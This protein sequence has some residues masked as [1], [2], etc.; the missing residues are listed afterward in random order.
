MKFRFIAVIVSCLPLAACSAGPK[1]EDVVNLTKAFGATRGMVI[2]SVKNLGC[3]KAKEGEVKDSG[4]HYR[5]K[6]ETTRGTQKGTD[7]IY[8][9]KMGENW[10]VKGT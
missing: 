7:T 4:E 2:D 5:C 3:E 1:D 10:L 6:V 8:F 9:Q